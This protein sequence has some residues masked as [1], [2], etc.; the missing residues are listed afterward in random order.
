[1]NDQASIINHQVI[2]ARLLVPPQWKAAR[3]EEPR[4]PNP[5]RSPALQQISGIPK[6]KRSALETMF[7]GGRAKVC[8]KMCLVMQSRWDLSWDG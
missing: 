8:A 4:G 2:I 1:M 6:Q 5:L 3:K 7:N